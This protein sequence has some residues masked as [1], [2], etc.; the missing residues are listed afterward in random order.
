MI[1]VDIEC[2]GLDFEKCGIWQTGLINPRRNKFSFNLIYGKGFFKEFE[3]FEIPKE[4][5]K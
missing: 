3:N 4:L 5:R 2:T 1:S